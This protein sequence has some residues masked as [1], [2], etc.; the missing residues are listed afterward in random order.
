MRGNGGRILTT[1]LFFFPDRN[2]RDYLKKKPC[3]EIF[4]DFKAVVRWIQLDR[5]G[6]GLKSRAA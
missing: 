1:L 5:S 3:N 6:G 2:F 4:C